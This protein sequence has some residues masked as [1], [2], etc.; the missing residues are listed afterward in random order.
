MYKHSYKNSADLWLF[1]QQTPKCNNINKPI[2]AKK[3][4]TAGPKKK[5]FAHASV[6]AY[7]ITW[8]SDIT[9]YWHIW[10]MI[11]QHKGA[12]ANCPAQKKTKSFAE[13]ARSK[14]RFAALSNQIIVMC[15][16]RNLKES[17]S[18]T[19]PSVLIWGAPS[20]DTP[21]QRNIFV[22]FVFL[23]SSCQSQSSDLACTWTAAHPAEGS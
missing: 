14:M 9:N 18:P 15:S 5:V 12:S 17:T 1:V 2:F 11:L 7:G 4:D 10:C 3:Y 19:F 20:W 6:P 23:T 8:Q 22:Y 16:S 21:T 13:S